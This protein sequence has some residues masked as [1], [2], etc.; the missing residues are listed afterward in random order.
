[1]ESNWQLRDLFV[2]VAEQKKKR[3]SLIGDNALI[4]REVVGYY[5]HCGYGYKAIVHL[6]KTHCD[7][8]FSERTLKRP[9]LKNKL[10]KNSNTDDSVLRAIMRM[11]IETSSQC[12]GN[13]GMWHLQ[14][15]SY[16][17]QMPQ[18]RVMQILQE[19]EPERTVQRSA[20]KLVRQHYCD[21]CDKMKPCGLSIYGALDGFSR[22]VIWL[23]VCRTNSNP[24]V[25]ATVYIRAVQ[26]LGLVPEMLRTDHGNEVD[27][28]TAA[29]CTFRQNADANMYVT[30]V[31]NQRIE[32][33][34]SHFRRTSTSWLVKFFK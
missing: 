21:N 2:L 4:E 30:S 12:L 6:L 5:V 32:N 16:S 20:H 24:M 3:I 10:R 14:R 31:A 26:S 29:H 25:V 17:I 15:K 8:S 34:W 13:I 9:L 28:M 7:I 23:E 18:D 11:E 22:K 27:V 19:E 33:L 1:M